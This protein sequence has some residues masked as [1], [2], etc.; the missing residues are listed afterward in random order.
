MKHTTQVFA[1]D[2]NYNTKLTFCLKAS[3]IRKAKTLIHMSY[4]SF[5]LKSATHTMDMFT[6]LLR[7]IANIFMV[8]LGRQKKISLTYCILNH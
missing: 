1:G 5:L 7:A 8:K 2:V 4:E 3:N 6:H